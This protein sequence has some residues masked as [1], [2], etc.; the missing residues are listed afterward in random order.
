MNFDRLSLLDNQDG[1]KKWSRV[2]RSGQCGW[3]LEDISPC[4]IIP[5]AYE[6]HN[7]SSTRN[8]IRI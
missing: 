3:L 6:L 7:R 2:I 8:R 5:E 4:S 1:D